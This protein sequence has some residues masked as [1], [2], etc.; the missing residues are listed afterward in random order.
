MDRI[1]IGQRLGKIFQN[2]LAREY[3]VEPLVYYLSKLVGNSK[4][5]DKHAKSYYLKTG[6]F[7]NKIIIS[8]PLRAAPTLGAGIDA[9]QN[10]LNE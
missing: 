7:D 8:S 1:V 4:S 10:Y 3:L 2:P 5:L 9:W 6:K